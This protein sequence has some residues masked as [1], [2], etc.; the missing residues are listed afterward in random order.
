MN[1]LRSVRDVVLVLLLL[2]CQNRSPVFAQGGPP[3]VEPD[4]LLKRLDLIGKEIELDD[5]ARFQFHP[6]AGY[7]QI[8]LRRA[9]EVICEIPSSLRPRQPS[10]QVVKVRGIL[11]R[12]N[13]RT[14]VEVTSLDLLPSDLDR[15]N[16]GIA[17][18]TKTDIDTR[19]SWV[20][21]AE[22]RIK[23]FKP[24]DARHEVESVDVALSARVSEIE[25]EVIRTESDRPARDLAA[26]WLGLAERARARGIPE[27]E[28]SA[29]AHRGFREA[30]GAARTA[31]ELN[32]IRM[33]VEAFFPSG[34]N[35]STTSPDLS[36]WNAPY[37]N[38]PA[39]AYRQAP[40]PAR[41]AF[42]HRLWSDVVQAWIEQRG[43]DD[44]K[45]LVSLS[46][47]A[48]RLLPDRPL[49]A[50]S[51][52][53]K[54][55]TRALGDVGA[56][57]LSEVDRLAKLYREKLKQPEKAKSLY[58]E[59]LEDQRL[60]RLSPRDADGRLALA[61]QYESL[62]GDKD[63][64]AELLRAAWAIDPLSKE[65]ADAFRRRGF[66]K[67]KDEWIAGIAQSSS[68]KSMVS[69]TEPLK[70]SPEIAEEV[71]S[72]GRGRGPAPRER[73]LLR[74]ASREEVRIELAGRPNRRNYV[75]SQGQLI[76]QWIYYQDKSTLYIN[77][78]LKSGDTL[79]RVV[80]Y[81]SLPR[82]TSDPA[83]AP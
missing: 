45:M 8:Y 59:W 82:S 43:K 42:D 52:L 64:A 22:N 2:A 27:P 75:A 38:A 81:Y 83:P 72:E 9:P 56:L 58:H 13:G 16:R 23:A 25:A 54:G 53:E 51:L 57:R 20:R 26:H 1:R 66:R 61:D 46:E 67:V 7:D 70:A 48:A 71:V 47:E 37:R 6:N 40:A 5:R 31:D 76:E 49:L 34:V 60:K 55:L 18:S 39:D 74:G 68:D 73:G 44:P 17:L 29:Q 41:E 35:P 62:L 15:F 30:L 65:T 36:K 79:P 77:F 14:F 80:S 32:E 11:R 78:R 24:K 4:T 3:V 50:T 69:D 63:T 12:E 28:P 19:M 33:K 21:W 10:A